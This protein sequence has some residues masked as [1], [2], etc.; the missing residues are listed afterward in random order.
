M[1][2]HTPMTTTKKWKLQV[3]LAGHKTNTS[4]MKLK[5]IIWLI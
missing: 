5:R 3:G 4:I 2:K 1:V